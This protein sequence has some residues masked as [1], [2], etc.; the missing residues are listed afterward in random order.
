MDKKL[1][2]LFC[3]SKFDYG[4]PRRG[5]SFETESF[6]PPLSRYGEIVEFDFPTVLKQ[7]GRQGMNEALLAE[8]AAPSST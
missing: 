7:S 3:A 1:K 4:D 2:I 5:P 6:H 8:L